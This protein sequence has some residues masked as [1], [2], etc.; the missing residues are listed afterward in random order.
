MIGSNRSSAL[1]G[2]VPGSHWKSVRPPLRHSV[3]EPQGT[4]SFRPQKLHGLSCQNA[5][6]T[7]AVGHDVLVPGK[8]RKVSFQML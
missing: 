1:S 3:F 8:P 5:I 4:E 6:G 2:F 7:A